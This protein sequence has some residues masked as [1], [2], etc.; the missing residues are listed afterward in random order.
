MV[1]IDDDLVAMWTCRQAIACREG[2]ETSMLVECKCPWIL[3]ATIEGWDVMAFVSEWLQSI[4]VGVGDDD[5]TLIIDAYSSQDW[6]T[7]LA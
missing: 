5:S 7:A 4:V 1:H 3:D 6:L 2:D